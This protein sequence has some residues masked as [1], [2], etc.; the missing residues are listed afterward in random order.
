M[1]PH[2]PKVTDPARYQCDFP[3]RK[4][5]RCPPQGPPCPSQCRVDDW[6]KLSSQFCLLQAMN[7]SAASK[8][9]QVASW[10]TDGCAAS[11]V[12]VFST[13]AL[14]D[15]EMWRV[16]VGVTRVPECA[17]NL[18]KLFLYRCLPDWVTNSLLETAASLH[19]F[20]RH[21]LWAGAGEMAIISEIKKASC[22][23]KYACISPSVL[24]LKYCFYTF[25]NIPFLIKL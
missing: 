19:A 22:D 10:D 8:N 4:G 12:P 2:L 25:D 14:G 7:A 1:L 13:H 23:L 5:I 16:C 17:F 21:F 11:S 6:N 24:S 18:S 20:G 9:G 3:L 15:P